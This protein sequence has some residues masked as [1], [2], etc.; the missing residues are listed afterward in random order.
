[1]SI[2]SGAQMPAGSADQLF[3]EQI[4]A[5]TKDEASWL[6]FCGPN[7]EATDPDQQWAV[8]VAGGWT[9]WREVRFYGRTR[10]AAVWKAS[11]AKYAAD[12][13]GEKY[14]GLQIG[15]NP[16]GVYVGVDPA[17]PG[18]DITVMQTVK[19]NNVPL[20]SLEPGEMF[21]LA[22]QAHQQV[23]KIYIKVEQQIR[24]RTAD[25]C[26][27][28]GETVPVHFDPMTPVLRI[29][30]IDVVHEWVDIEMGDVEIIKGP[31]NSGG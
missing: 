1:M 14:T 25:R 7:V 28:I 4:E 17:K 12:M 22:S 29:K 27:K 19:V 15:M 3:R 20:G 13:V 5:L 21:I 18:G 23:R 6:V 16:G 24:K 2:L 9:D 10:Q 8:D 31:E 11:R 30:P 26:Y